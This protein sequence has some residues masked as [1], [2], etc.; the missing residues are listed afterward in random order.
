MNLVRLRTGS[1]GLPQS[2]YTL[3][4]ILADDFPRT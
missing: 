4:V 1:P 3:D 2:W